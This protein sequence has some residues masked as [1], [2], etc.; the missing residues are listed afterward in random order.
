VAA[1]A[2]ASRP[3]PGLTR[4]LVTG[5]AGFIGSHLVPALLERGDEVLIVDD[6]STGKRSNIAPFLDAGARLSET[7]I[8]EPGALEAAIGA[9]ELDRVFHIAGQVDVRKA[10][11]DPTYDAR[12]NVIGTIEVLEAARRAGC[13]LVFTSTGG[14]SYGE[15]EGRR[16][17]FTE[18]DAT[19]PETAYGVSKLSAEMYVS[20]YRLL[21]GLPTV[22]LRLGN[23]YGPR[24]D[25][26]GEAGVVAIYCGLLLEGEAPIVFGDGEQTRD[27]IYV[28]D[29]VAGLLAAEAGL[30]AGSATRDVYN[31]GT[32]IETS[33][34]QIAAELGRIAGSSPAPQFRPHRAGEIQRV[35]ISPESAGRDLGWAAATGLDD[36]LAETF[37]W[38]RGELTGS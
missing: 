19:V 25:P 22:S 34:L 36:G 23:V 9:E 15:G 28:G 7:D 14:A 30:S 29:V 4:S 31:I 10:I 33:V 32:G 27:Y 8:A 18:D 6:L 17:P 3:D 20:F 24:Q 21:H 26:H 1:T 12:V 37:A 35:A 11:A 2:A 16:L 38:A 5:G 13:P